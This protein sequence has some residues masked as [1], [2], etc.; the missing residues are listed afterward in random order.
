VTRERH[1]RRAKRPLAYAAVV[2]VTALFAAASVAV[3]LTS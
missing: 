2:V 3:L 1:P